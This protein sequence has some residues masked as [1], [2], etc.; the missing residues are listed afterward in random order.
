MLPEHALVEPRRVFQGGTGRIRVRPQALG[1]NRDSLAK[2]AFSQLHHEGDGVT[3]CATG[4]TAKPLLVRKDAKGRPSTGRMKRAL[5][6]PLRALRCELCALADH[7]QQVNFLANPFEH[8]RR[9]EFL[10][11]DAPSRRGDLQFAAWGPACPLTEPNRAEGAGGGR[12]R[13]DA[14]WPGWRERRAVSLVWATSCRA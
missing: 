5:S 13:P 14:V 6:S 3:F 9:D 4:K 10:L 8:S 1:Q 7:L 12:D 11:H 2:R